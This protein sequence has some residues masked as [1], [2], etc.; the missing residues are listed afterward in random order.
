MTYGDLPFNAWVLTPV[1]DEGGPYGSG[2]HPGSSTESPTNL[3]F[4]Y[5]KSVGHTRKSFK[6]ELT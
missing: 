5:D 4:T 3:S 6:P 2:K 1:N